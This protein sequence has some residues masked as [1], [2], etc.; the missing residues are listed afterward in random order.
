MAFENIE[1]RRKG[2]VGLDVLTP[3]RRKNKQFLLG[4]FFSAL[5]W[6]YFNFIYHRAAY[7]KVLTFFV[8]RECQKK[9]LSAQHG[10]LQNAR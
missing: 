3:S 10:R 2:A 8:A 6:N 7:R 9:F 4:E 5:K 1:L